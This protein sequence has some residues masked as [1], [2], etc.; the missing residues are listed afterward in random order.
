MRKGEIRLLILGL[1]SFFLTIICTVVAVCLMIGAVAKEAEEK[2]LG[3]KI[4]QG[5]ESMSEKVFTDDDIE[6]DIDV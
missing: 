6:V 4:T 5:I 3:G 1:V 2:D